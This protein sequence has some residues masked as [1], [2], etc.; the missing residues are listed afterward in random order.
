M[1][2]EAPSRL[3]VIPW[4]KS[5]TLSKAAEF[6]SYIAVSSPLLVAVILPYYSI[7]DHNFTQNF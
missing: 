2:P 3:P 7:H 5:V 1:F 6:F 4:M